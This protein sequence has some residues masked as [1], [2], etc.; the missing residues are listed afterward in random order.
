MF[1]FLKKDNIFLGILLGG[2]IPLAA[3]A[4]MYYSSVLFKS[5][6]LAKSIAPS[7]Q[8]VSIFINLFLL[9]FYLLKQKYDKTGRG[10]LLITFIYAII[11]FIQ[12]LF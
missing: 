1:N 6:I 9:R 11:Y 3:F 12:H 2:I 7:L 4:I 10:I 5:E 8:L